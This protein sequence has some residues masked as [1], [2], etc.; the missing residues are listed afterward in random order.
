MYRE[1]RQFQ[2]ISGCKHLTVD[3]LVQKENLELI[4]ISK[5]SKQLFDICLTINADCDEIL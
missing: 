3:I 2:A 1:L 4:K 5:E